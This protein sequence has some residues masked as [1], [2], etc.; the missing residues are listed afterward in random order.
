ML[1]ETSVSS[2]IVVLVYNQS[3]GDVKWMKQ[4]Q[5]SVKYGLLSQ[6]QVLE[7]LKARGDNLKVYTKE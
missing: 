3:A 4:K 5:G 6:R 7:K 1:W 2:T